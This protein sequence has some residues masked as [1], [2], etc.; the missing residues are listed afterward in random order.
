MKGLAPVGRRPCVLPGLEAGGSLFTMASSSA[1]L[2]FG[3]P[4]VEITV[5]SQS[6]EKR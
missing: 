3:R 2:D 4:M 1:L 5:V 6:S